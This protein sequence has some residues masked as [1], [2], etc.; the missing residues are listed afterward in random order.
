M[1]EE[2]KKIHQ[3]SC[4]VNNSGT[5]PAVEGAKRMFERSIAK[6]NLPYTSYYGDGD[7]K[8][9]EAVISTRD[10]EKPVQKFEYIGHYQKRVGCRLR[11]LKKNIK[12][13]KDLT[14]PVIDK[15]QNYFGIALRAKCTTVEDMQKAIWASYFHVASN[16]QNNYH[17][18]CE[19][20]STRWCQYQRYIINKTNFYKHGRGLSQEVI[21]WVKPIYLDLIKPSELKKC[22][23]GKHK[24]KMRVLILQYGN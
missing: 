15:L 19:A 3:E 24:I 20:S 21:K 5:A 8:A 22:L 17:D 16:E 10:V 13:L 1:F 11:K 12:G 4:K 9:Y 2:W 23:Y 7:S 18:H 14:P 6:R